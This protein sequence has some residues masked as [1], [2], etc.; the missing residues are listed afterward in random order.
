M[1]LCQGMG[2]LLG[3]GCCPQSLQ[4]LSAKPSVLVSSMT[5]LGLRSASCLGKGLGRNGEEETGLCF[6]MEHPVLNS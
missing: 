4:N 1:E 6:F 3:A 5:A 2:R